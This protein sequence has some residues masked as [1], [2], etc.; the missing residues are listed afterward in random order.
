MKYFYQ[1]DTG[2]HFTFQGE[3]YEKLDD[4]S[5]LDVLTAALKP[6]NAVDQVRPTET[7]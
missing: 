1:L 5:A 4:E 3:V 6:F 2:D 7:A